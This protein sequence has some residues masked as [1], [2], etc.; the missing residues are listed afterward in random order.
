MKSVLILVLGFAAL[1]VLPLGAQ[2]K[3]SAEKAAPK[4]EMPFYGNTKCPY[5]GKAIKKQHFVSKGKERIYLCC[6]R[7][8]KKAKTEV[9]KL[10]AL[11]YPKSE[12]QK[13]SLKA[14]PLTHKKLGEKPVLVTWQGYQIP[15]C[16]KRCAKGFLRRPNRNLTIALHPE[17]KVVGN[18]MC[19][20]MDDEKVARDTFVVYRGYLVDLCCEECIAMFN[21]DGDEYLLSLGVKPPKKKSSSKQDASKGKKR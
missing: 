8:V 19:P 20:V 12:L 6:S 21:D 9:D 11:A 3:S 1:L 4:A 7:C 10:Y 16:C 13:L 18:K 2:E 14:C 17:L 15:V 5:S